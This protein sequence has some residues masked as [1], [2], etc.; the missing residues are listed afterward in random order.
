MVKVIFFD[1]DGTLVSHTKKEVS[2]S[3]RTALQQLRQKGILCVLATG[4]HMAELAGLPL[5]DIAF[6]AYLTL[7]GQ[8]CLDSA[9]NTIFANPIPQQD[10]E[11]LTRLFYEK[12]CPIMLNEKDKRYINFID[13]R[14][15]KAQGDISSPLPR[16]ESSCSGEDI[17]QA[18]AF[19]EQCDEEAIARLLQDCTLT[20]WNSCGIDIIARSEGKAAGIRE[21]LN[22]TGRALKVTA[23]FGDGENDRDMLRYVHLGV[24]MGNADDGTKQCA[25]YVTTD[26]DSDGISHALHTLGILP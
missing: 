3:T 18:M 12:H 4:R 19:I 21:Y 1:A 25:D 20:R 7:N 22:H 24:A 13:A 2:E 15:E 8:L 14:V 10:K 23:A 26:V 6:D 9:G 11:Q 16:V 5:R 17:F